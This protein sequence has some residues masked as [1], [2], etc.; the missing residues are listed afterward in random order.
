MNNKTKK[1]NNVFISPL[2]E[3]RPFRGKKKEHDLQLC[4]FVADVYLP[5]AGKEKSL[6][7]SVSSR[8][9]KLSLLLVFFFCLF[10]CLFVYVSDCFTFSSKSFSVSLFL[11][12]T[13]FHRGYIH[14]IHTAFETLYTLI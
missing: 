4:C 3:K 12:F 1:K 5:V 7:S 2:R 14:L 6:H 11:F 10:V 8:L 13:S 9:V